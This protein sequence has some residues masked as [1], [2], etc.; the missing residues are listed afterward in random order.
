[1][2]VSVTRA[3]E[4]HHALI[5]CSL[6]RAGSEEEDLGDDTVGGWIGRGAAGGWRMVAGGCD[7]KVP[8]R[9]AGGG[10]HRRRSPAPS[11]RRPPRR[12]SRQPLRRASSA[13]SSSS[14]SSSSSPPSW[15]GWDEE[16]TLDRPWFVRGPSSPWW[17]GS[18]E[19][20]TLDRSW[21]TRGRRAP[22]K[23]DANWGRER[24]L[25]PTPQ[26]PWAV[27]QPR[28]PRKHPRQ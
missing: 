5:V 11:S 26:P 23:E 16:D 12:A 20:D 27:A 18:S 24:R 7:G 25:A 4:P 6:A 19:E 10:G 2:C 22:R 15:G 1:M 8:H 13:S 9:A 17:G 3:R 21:S 28:D 14:S